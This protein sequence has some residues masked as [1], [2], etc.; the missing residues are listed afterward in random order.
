MKQKGKDY[1]VFPVVWLFNPNIN[2]II[3]MQKGKEKKRL[4]LLNLF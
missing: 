2:V 1:L 3:C 4:L